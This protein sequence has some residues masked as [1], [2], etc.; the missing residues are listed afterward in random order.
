M[1]GAFEVFRCHRS[2]TSGSR[3]APWNRTNQGEDGTS[4]ASDGP[5]PWFTS[6]TAYSPN[7]GSIRPV[8]GAFLG[9]VRKSI[10]LGQFSLFMKTSSAPPGH[11]TGLSSLIL[12]LTCQGASFKLLGAGFRPRGD[13]RL[14]K[15]AVLARMP[16][17]DPPLPPRPQGPDSLHSLMRRL[18]SVPMLPKK[19]PAKWRFH[20]NVFPGCTHQNRRR[21]IISTSVGAHAV[22]SKTPP[23][24]R[25][26]RSSR[27]LG[28]TK[29]CSSF[30]TLPVGFGSLGGEESTTV[31]SDERWLRCR[32]R[33]VNIRPSYKG[34]TSCV[35]ESDGLLS[36]NIQRREGPVFVVA[37]RPGLPGRSLQNKEAHNLHLVGALPIDSGSPPIQ[38]PRRPSREFDFNGLGAS[39]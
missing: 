25:S 19:R 26:R 6:P 13:A 22:A 31:R 1:G 33:S 35:D 21:S 23:S 5:C 28:F 39:L 8:L 24:H 20:P 7:F 38:G 11:A 15:T 16:I 36:R 30:Q 29:G 17:S 10:I 3:T 4:S 2:P 27:E 34:Q 18:R 32:L 37:I 9:V 12:R 14:R